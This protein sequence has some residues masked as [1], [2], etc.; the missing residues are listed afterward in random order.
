[1]TRKEVI[2]TSGQFSIYGV[3][4]FSTYMLSAVS[5]Y[6]EDFQMAAI[7]LGFGALLGFIRRVA[8]IWE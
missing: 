4:R 3:F 5:L 6:I 7:T 1:M 2:K 8:R